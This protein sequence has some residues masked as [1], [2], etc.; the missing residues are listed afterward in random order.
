MERKIIISCFIRLLHPLFDIRKRFNMRLTAAL[1]TDA[2]LSVP[3]LIHSVWLEFDFAFYPYILYHKPNIPIAII[4]AKDNKH[5]V[6]AGI[7]LM[8]IPFSLF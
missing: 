3:L 4:E 6:K 1:K 5:S 7:Q 2:E 8:G